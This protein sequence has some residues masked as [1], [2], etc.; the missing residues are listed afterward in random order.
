MQSLPVRILACA[1]ERI[2]RGEKQ[3]KK[4]LRLAISEA[5]K[6]MCQV[7]GAWRRG[8]DQNTISGALFNQYYDANLKIYSEQNIKMCCD[9]LTRRSLQANGV[10]L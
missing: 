6:V 3:V 4:Y 7:A 10:Q 8:E 1:H 2:I 9:L 5:E